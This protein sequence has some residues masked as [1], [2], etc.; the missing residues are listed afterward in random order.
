MIES[1]STTPGTGDALPASAVETVGAIGATPA[2]GAETRINANAGLV[3]TIESA[4]STSPDNNVQAELVGMAA[5][6]GISPAEIGPVAIKAEPVAESPEPITNTLTAETIPTTLS[7]PRLFPYVAEAKKA[8]AE[9]KARG[10]SQSD[11]EGLEI[12]LQQATNKEGLL[13]SGVALIQIDAEIVDAQQRGASAEE[14]AELN[15]R[16]LETVKT[17][18]TLYEEVFKQIKAQ[19]KR[20]KDRDPRSFEQLVDDYILK[21]AAEIKDAMQLGLTRATEAGDEGEIETAKLRLQAAEMHFGIIKKKKGRGLRA[22]LNSIILSAGA[23]ALGE[24][25]KVSKGELTSEKRR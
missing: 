9:A 12:K 5:L 16:K 13:M 20:N 19:E 4:M 22:L 14:L 23:T 17:R 11:I 6:A 1:M 2:N 10:A 18:E 15:S 25:F 7:E 21:E 24:T 3:G 8:L